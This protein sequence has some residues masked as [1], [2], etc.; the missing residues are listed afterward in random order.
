MHPV[1]RYTTSPELLHR[2]TPIRA[3][4]KGHPQLEKGV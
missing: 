2:L 3:S 4:V 1:Y